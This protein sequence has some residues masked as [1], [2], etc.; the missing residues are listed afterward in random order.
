MNFRGVIRNVIYNPQ[1]RL[2]PLRHYALPHFDINAASASGV[3]DLD[4]DG[5]AVGYSKWVSPKRTR[6]FPFARIY[7]TYHL[8]KKITIIPVIKDEGASTMNN[9]R[10]NFITLS[11]MNLSNIYIILAWYDTAKPHRNRADAV[12]AQQFDPDYIREKIREIHEYQQSALHWNVMHFERDFETIYT[13]AV[14]R[15]RKISTTYAIRMHN[16]D[17]HLKVLE[18]FRQAGRFDLQTFKVLTLASS[19]SA[20]QREMQTTHAREY[21]VEGQK[22]YFSMTNMLGGEYHLTADEI[23]YEDE[24]IL[25]QEAKNSTRDKLPSINDVQDGLFKLILF[26]NIDELYLNNHRVNFQT[27]L[28]IT[29]TVEGH[30]TLPNTPDSID[31]FCHLN[32]LTSSKRQLVDALNNE[33]I[34]N[35]SLSIV[36]GSYS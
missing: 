12:T 24:T 3:I 20:A 22:A 33:A 34:Q 29:G 28:K 35:P 18:D 4:E 23:L 13:R 14:D 11:W 16:F 15:Y 1:V 10:I 32:S 8:P 9:D 31:D 25:I 7:T 26:A 6:S 30:L 5:S 2:K 17:D 36:I 27:R 19:F 21:L